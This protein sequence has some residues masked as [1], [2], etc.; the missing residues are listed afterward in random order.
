MSDD[1]LS[2]FDDVNAPPRD[3]E[4]E[5][6]LASMG[7]ATPASESVT[8]SS[9]VAPDPSKVIE[10]PDFGP[11]SPDPTDSIAATL[12]PAQTGIPTRDPLKDQVPAVPREAPGNVGS[13]A[14]LPGS[15]PGAT[16]PQG[17]A[18][19]TGEVS[20]ALGRQQEARH[21]GEEAQGA[22]DEAGQGRRDDEYLAAVDR[23]KA[24]EE[25][26]KAAELVQKKYDIADAAATKQL[27]ETQAAL[28][29]FK[30]RDFW[31]D[32]TTGQ[33]VLSALAA[34]LG[35]FGAGLTKTPNYALKTLDKAMEDDHG[36]Q[37]QQLKMLTDQEVM[38]HTGIADARAAR[39]RAMADLTLAD[40]QKDRLI[41]S[42]LEE[43]AARSTDANYKNVVAADVAKRREAAAAKDVEAHKM[44]RSMNLEDQEK[45]ARIGEINARTAM[46]NSHAAG[47]GGFVPKHKGGSGGGGSS[48]AQQG[49][50]TLS[51]EIEAAKASGTPMPF[52]TMQERAVALG[53]P[54][55]AKAGQTSLAS[56]IADSSKLAKAGYAENTNDLKGAGAVNDFVKT[57]LAGD[58]ELTADLKENQEVGKALALAKP[59]PDG[60]VSGVNFQQ[61][62]DATVKAA[63]GLGARPGSIA[64]FQGSLGG[65]WD[66]VMRA[67]QHG[68]T[69]QYTA[70]DVQVLNDALKK[71][72]A[73]VDGN[74]RDK[75]AAYRTEFGEHPTT[76]G[77]EDAWGA[78]L[79]A[80]FGGHG[81][82]GTSKLAQAKA[83]LADPKNASDPHR[84]G[85]EAKVKAMEGGAQ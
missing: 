38:A 50:V 28:K 47:T 5:R 84:A 62:I 53:I 74:L 26:I 4:D 13:P 2:D 9:P 49:A 52:A 79:K 51:K 15:A 34:A 44:L 17:A 59:G 69:G 19:A 31:A 33:F 66:K 63:T 80:R 32:K 56:V 85:V 67:I 20:D 76:K 81:G 58:K 42:Q 3:D 35:G 83:W 65:V 78:E 40:A 77:H 27:A 70:H 30:F 60:N 24:A 1:L 41:S 23:R 8:Q 46:E 12:P 6:I 75:E 18:G 22:L 57:R 10:S 37:V 43:A 7:S 16:A 29:N 14:P 36:K 68:E 71:Q 21:A 61:A 72:K 11:P 73:Y 64:V 45:Q 39:T 55:N 25:H 54:L 82:G 48:K